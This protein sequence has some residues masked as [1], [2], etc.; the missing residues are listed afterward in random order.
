MTEDVASEH[1]ESA[2]WLFI[3]S[4]DSNKY[5]FMRVKYNVQAVVHLKMSP[6]ISLSGIYRKSFNLL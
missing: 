5:D 1:P 3:V 4:L 6:T 2:G